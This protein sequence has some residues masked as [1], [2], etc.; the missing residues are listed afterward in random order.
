MMLVHHKVAHRQVGI[1]FHALARRLFALL[2]RALPAAQHDLTFRDDRQAQRREFK[3]GRESALGAQRLPVLWQRFAFHCRRVDAFIEQRFGH[4][5]R[6]FASARENQHPVVL[7]QIAPDIRRRRLHTAAVRGQLLGEDGHDRARRE[8]VRL[9]QKRVECDHVLFFDIIYKLTVINIARAELWHDQPALRQGLD[10]LTHTKGKGLC[11]F[12]H[13]PAVGEK[14]KRILRQIVQRGVE[15]IRV[16]GRQVPVDRRQGAELLEALGVARQIF[17]KLRPLG[18]VRCGEFIQ[19]LCQ[20]LDARRAQMGQHLAA[21]QDQRALDAL[22]A[23]LAVDAE[24]GERIQLVAEKFRAYRVFRFRR[25]EVENIAAHRELPRPL[26]RGAARV[27]RARQLFEQVV[28]K[29]RLPARQGERA[30]FKHLRRDGRGHERFHRRDGHARSVRHHAVQRA[31]ALVLPPVGGAFDIVEHEF[32]RRQHRRL[33]TGKAEEILRHAPRGVLIRRHD[34]R[35]ARETFDRSRGDARAVHVRQT[36]D[37]ARR[38]LVFD[39]EHQLRK[40]RELCKE[41][42]ERMHAAPAFSLL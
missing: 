30:L 21:R 4:V 22:A 41:R 28:E 25:V 5:L 11:R 36:G 7:C 38:P 12:A 26:D 29:I 2:F 31:D 23:A 42:S 17:G 3:A 6:A 37:R 34:Q 19:K 1:R 16:N 10:V 14:D 13:A 8:I 33:D 9:R 15:L 24:V 35:R 20:T 32:A 40:F 18:E 27:A 39:F